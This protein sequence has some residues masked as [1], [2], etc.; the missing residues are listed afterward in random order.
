MTPPK[1]A[2]T[3]PHADEAALRE[4]EDEIARQDAALETALAALPEG[5]AAPAAISSEALAALSTL[6]AAPQR[7][8]RLN[9][10]APFPG[11]RC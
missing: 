7:L 1:P 6:C 9:L 11:T 8:S 3:E 10:C 2:L 5:R 4:F